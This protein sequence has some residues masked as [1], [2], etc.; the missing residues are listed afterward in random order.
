MSKYYDFFPEVMKIIDLE[1]FPFILPKKPSPVRSL[2]EK[3]VLNRNLK[4][5]IE[6]EMDGVS[7]IRGMVQNHLGATIFGVSSTWHHL[8]ETGELLAIPFSSPSVK[9]KMYLIRNKKEM[10]SMAV[11]KVHELIRQELNTMLDEGVWPYG[12]KTS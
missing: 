5:N 4:L 8:V 10:D 3:I 9:W 2:L 7:S 6:Y 12:K 1:K 11:T